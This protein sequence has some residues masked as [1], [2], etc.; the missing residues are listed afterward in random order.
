VTRRWAPFVAVEFAT[1]L[2]GIANGI[3]MVAFPWLVLE[4]TGSAAAAGTIAA[5]T[6]VPMVV[7]S[8]FSGTVV[9]RVGRRFTSVVSD[10]L[11]LLS[12]LLVPL[13]AALERLDVFLLAVVAILGAVFDPAGVTAREAMLPGAA[14]A[15]NLPLERVN[16][17]HEAVWNVAFVIGPAIGG[18]LV[19]LVGAITTFW[20]T[21][22]AFALSAAAIALVA[23][24]DAGRPPAHERHEGIWKATG[25]G[26][27]FLW[28]DGL[29]RT[30]ALY[31]TVLVAAWMPL[32][33][34]V[35]PV[36]FEARD[37]PEELGLVLL[38]ASVGAIAGSLVYAAAG[39]RAGS[40]RRLFIASSILTAL[41]LVALAALPPLWAIILLITA[42]GFF[43]GPVNPL[44]NLAMQRRT[45]PR[46]LGRVMGLMNSVAWAA[47]PLGYLLAGWLYQAAGP[48]VTFGVFG[49]L[50]TGASLVLFAVPRLRELDDLPTMELE[51]T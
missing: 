35:L 43:W 7:A 39:P 48:A 13:A 33:A 25:E 5:I 49:L 29:L 9:D 47:A 8:V 34:I 27:R 4:V 10:I 6:A 30:L 40:R 45:P 24:P 31:Y 12:V 14:R 37:M 32:Q 3:T 41:P 42:S 36:W 1:V 15:A 16:G 51:R 18:L 38:M 22:V 50:L 2:A 44:V 21:A 20:A 23:V 26:L 17:V 28:G 46:M 11:S 19:G